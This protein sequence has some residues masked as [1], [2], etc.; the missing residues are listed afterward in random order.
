MVVEVE[1]PKPPARVL[2]VD[3]EGQVLG[4]M[5]SI[6]AKKLLEGYR[7]V[8][9]NAEKAVVS[10]DPLMVI[11]SYQKLLGVKVHVNPYKW[12]PRR[13]RDPRWIVRDAVEGMLPRWKE[14]GRKAAKRLRV[15]IGVPPEYEK[16]EKVKFPEADYRR[17]GHKFILVGEIARAMGWKGVA[18]RP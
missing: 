5:A 7:V 11:E 16:A 17:L 9:V 14:Q 2:V 3:A 18:E 15:Y 10:G 6:V 1:P 4:R 13:P 12:G 8:I